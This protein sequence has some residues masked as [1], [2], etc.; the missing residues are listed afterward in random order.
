[1]SGGVIIA[2]FIIDTLNDGRPNRAATHVIKCGL[3]AKKRA[4][5]LPHL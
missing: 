2:W 5:V 1:M 4:M 3:N